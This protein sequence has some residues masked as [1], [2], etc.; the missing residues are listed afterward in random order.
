M[1]TFVYERAAEPETAVHLAAVAK[2]NGVG[3]PAEYLAGGTTLL[4]LMKLNVVRPE[5]VVDINP[6]AAAG[7]GRI[8]LSQN[9][10]RPLSEWRKPPTIP[11]SNRNI[12]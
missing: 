4:D 9:G 3:K 11:R 8:E 10:L 7:Y 12:P 1:R 2:T 5:V 6:L